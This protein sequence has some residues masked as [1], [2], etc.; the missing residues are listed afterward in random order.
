MSNRS[1]SAINKVQ[2]AIIVV[3][4]AAAVV[5]GAYYTLVAQPGAEPVRI[6]IAGPLGFI[7]GKSI[8]EGAI[9]A[10]EEINAKGGLLGR[11]LQLFEGDTE[12]ANPAIPVERGIAAMEKLI[13]VDKVHVIIGGFRSDVVIAMED[14]AARN[15]VVFIGVGS[16]SPTMTQRVLDEYDKYKYFFRINPVNSTALALTLIEVYKGLKPKTGLENVYIIAEDIAAWKAL[17]PIIQATFPRLGYKVVGT[18][19]FPL[20]TSDFSAELAK[21]RDSGAQLVTQLLSGGDSIAFVKQ[22]RDQKIPALMV[23]IDVLA[24][25]QEFWDRTE[26]KAIYETLLISFARAP[27]TDKTIDWYDTYSKRWGRAPIYLAPGA[28]HAVLVF[29]QAVEKA[30]SLE[31]DALVKALEQTDFRGITGRIKFTRSHD[32]TWGYD[33]AMPNAVQWQG[34][35]KQITL[36]PD[37]VKVGELIVP[38]EVK[39]S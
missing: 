17:V 16:A 6:G 30:K 22:Y 20:G 24:Q 9:M 37:A 3:V 36:F 27:V 1:I 5:G 15:K 28:Y 35:E 23:G 31:S 21:I 2:A 25:E 10:V 33:F 8:R 39:R 19:Y 7:Q 11:P 26:G 12:E 18:A 34:K 29:A 13:N 4:L 38:P 32:I 14:V